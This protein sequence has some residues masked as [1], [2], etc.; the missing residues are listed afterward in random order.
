MVYAVEK[1][2][3]AEAVRDERSR[4]HP[5]LGNRLRGRIL[6][7]HLR[8]LEVGGWCTGDDRVKKWNMYQ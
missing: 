7:I 3:I 6:L 2:K 4:N 5:Y 1:W 8:R